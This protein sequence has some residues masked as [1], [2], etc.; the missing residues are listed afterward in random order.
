MFQLQAKTK[1]A[2]LTSHQFNFSHFHFCQTTWAN[3]GKDGILQNPAT[4]KLKITTAG[5]SGVSNE[6]IRYQLR[7]LLFLPSPLYQSHYQTSSNE[8]NFSSACHLYA[9]SLQFSF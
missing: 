2:A 3:I 7:I 8:S 4:K 1:F 6:D 9:V 5:R